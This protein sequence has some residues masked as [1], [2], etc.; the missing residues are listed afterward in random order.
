MDNQALKPNNLFNEF[1]T[2]AEEPEKNVEEN[3][4]EE[5]VL[6]YLSHLKGWKYLK[7][8][9]DRLCEELD[10]FVTKSIENGADS[11]EV[12]ERTIAKEIAKAYVRRFI[13]KVEDARSAI[14][15][16]ETD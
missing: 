11:K 5:R 1:S 8:Y 6:A 4:E 2:L 15:G 3:T 7:E 12:G 14:G 16:R 13:N 10:N 9:A